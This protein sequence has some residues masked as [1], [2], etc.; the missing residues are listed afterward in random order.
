MNVE[1]E[2]QLAAMDAATLVQDGMRVGL[3]TG[4]T[5]A[6]LLSALAR[7]DVKAVYVAT[8]PETEARARSLGVATQP[9]DT[10]NL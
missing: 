3:G 5:V 6:Y 1:R 7:R 4:S 9:F 8:S 2:K 10:L